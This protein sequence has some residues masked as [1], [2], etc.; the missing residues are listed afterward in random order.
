M[1]KQILKALVSFLTE[2]EKQS[3]EPS[4]FF[5]QMKSSSDEKIRFYSSLFSTIS[6]EEWD[7]IASRV[8]VTYLREGRISE[9]FSINIISTDSEATVQ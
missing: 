2:L 4:V 6:D 8:Q 7:Y 3:I 5:N 1:R 9:G